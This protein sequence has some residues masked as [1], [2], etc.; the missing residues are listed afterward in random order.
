M[1]SDLD[2]EKLAQEAYDTSNKDNND[3]IANSVAFFIE[4]EVLWFVLFVFVFLLFVGK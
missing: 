1:E 3:A 2:Y 4:V